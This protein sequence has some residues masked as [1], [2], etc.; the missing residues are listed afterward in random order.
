MAKSRLSPTAKKLK[1]AY[2]RAWAA[3]NRNKCKQW[4]ANYWE[5]KAAEKSMIDDTVKVIV[6]QKEVSVA[7]KEVSVTTCLWCG[8]HFKSQRKT[9]RFCT[10]ICRVNYNRKNHA[11]SK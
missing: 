2:Q 6:T 10:P 9:A 3:K 11:H 5:R 1:A 7:Q 4:Q 8:E